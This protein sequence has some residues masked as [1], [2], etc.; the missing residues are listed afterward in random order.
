ME[1]RS[2]TLIKEFGFII[3]TFVFAFAILFLFN[4]VV[5]NY[6]ASVKKSRLIDKN[7]T[8]LIDN[9]YAYNLHL[10]KGNSFLRGENWD[11]A[12]RYYQKALVLM[13][14]GKDANVGLA[15]TLVNKCL[16]TEHYCNSA[17]DYL[18][19]CEQM[20]FMTEAES[21]GIWKKLNLKRT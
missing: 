2:K 1:N 20:S 21:N 8:D 11:E 4:Q 19:F 17:K 9:R 3:L 7:K 10:S 12:H 18:Q 6:R 16:L 14:Y 5:G 13:P 15:K